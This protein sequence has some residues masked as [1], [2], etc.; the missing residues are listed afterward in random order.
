MQEKIAA[1]REKRDKLKGDMFKELSLY[2]D[3][4][5]LN[6]DPTKCKLP[7]VPENKEPIDIIKRRPYKNVLTKNLFP[8]IEKDES[9]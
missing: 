7:T 2:K 9:V 3:F 5:R 4:D 8:R 1:Y 6:A